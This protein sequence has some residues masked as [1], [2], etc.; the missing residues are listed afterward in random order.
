ML[1]TRRCHGLADD[2]GRATVDDTLLVTGWSSTFAA[3][4]VAHHVASDGEDLPM[5][6]QI[7]VQAG[8]A[9]GENAG[10]LLGGRELEA[11]ELSHAGWVLDL[12]GRR[13]LAEVAGVELAAPFLDLL[14]PLLHWGIDVKHLVETRGLAGL[15][16]RPGA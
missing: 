8:E 3:G 6:A 7:A 13:G 10:R 12:G 9:A 15:A 4:D 2:T 16:K 11:A 14:P 1:S 5:S